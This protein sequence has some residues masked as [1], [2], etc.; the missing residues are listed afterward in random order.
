MC[1]EFGTKVPVATC[2]TSCDPALG[3]CKDCPKLG[4]YCDGLTLK[5]C[6]SEGEFA[7]VLEQC[8]STCDATKLN[9]CEECNVGPGG[10][11]YCDNDV[12]TDCSYLGK[13]SML[14][15]CSTAQSCSDGLKY[16]HCG[17][18]TQS[19]A[20]TTPT[21]QL[22]KIGNPIF[23]PIGMTLFAAPA[24]TDPIAMELIGSTA[25]AIYAGKHLLNT[26]L[27]A[28][29]PGTPHQPPYD[30]EIPNGVA[31]QGYFVSNTF[32]DCQL[33]PTSGVYFLF[34]VAPDVGAPTG[35]S[36]DFTSGPIVPNTIFPMFLG[37]DLFREGVLVDPTGD[38]NYPPST[39]ITPGT[40]GYSH[41]P[42]TWVT[43]EGWIPK[44]TPVKGNYS[45]KLDLI[46][47]NGNGWTITVPYK[48]Q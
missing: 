5:M 46:D 26:T 23:K 36:A 47:K 30:D 22:T 33:Y 29:V 3:R 31:A 12:L 9:P 48:V 34:F 27:N 2:T 1:T 37:T 19:V 11:V 15:Q 35:K 18:T 20:A 21:Y 28:L 13:K 16:G 4:Q 43:G 14:E 38:S 40:D 6:G 17:C 7:G 10:G 32:A 39:A 24:G 44:G 45:W 41:L 25:Q 42:V 8:N